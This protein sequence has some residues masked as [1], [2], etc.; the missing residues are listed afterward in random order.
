MEA[1]DAAVAVATG[2]A[3]G[4]RMIPAGVTAA[5]AE[6]QVIPSGQE[7]PT[8]ALGLDRGGRSTAAAPAPASATS[9]CGRRSREAVAPASWQPLT[10]PKLAL[11]G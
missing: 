11:L 4:V 1:A 3:V 5:E 7:A 8:L 2:A 6:L 9:R 10:R